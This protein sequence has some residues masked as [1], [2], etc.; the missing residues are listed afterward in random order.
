MSVV[1]A[2]I[3]ICGPSGAGKTTIAKKMSEKLSVAYI[4]ADEFYKKANGDECVHTNKFEVWMG[5]FRA[6]HECEQ[7]KISCIVD[8][9][10]LSSSGRD[11]F[12]NWFPGFHHYM[13]YVDADDSLRLENNKRRRRQ[14]PDDIMLGMRV[15]AE[16]PAWRTLDKKWRAL[17]RIQ[18]VDNKYRVIQKEGEV[19]PLLLR[20][21]VQ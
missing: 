1:P 17:I 14:I 10:A 4:G 3:L 20:A 7:G 18:N 2:L 8:S 12:I 21:I 11:E 9:N 6:I 19:M 15:K 16:P 13:I 5:L